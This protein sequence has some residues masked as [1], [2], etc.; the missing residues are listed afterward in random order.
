MQM[1]IEMSDN[2]VLWQSD[3]IQPGY[4]F[5]EIEL[6]AP[7]ETGIYDN[8]QF[9]VRCFDKTGAEINGGNIQFTLYVY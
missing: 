5:Y 9:F 7:L 1:R 8:C 2:T 6:A 4:G 3:S